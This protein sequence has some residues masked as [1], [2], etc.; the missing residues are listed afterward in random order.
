MA[1]R[2]PGG[3]TRVRH[4]GRGGFT[5]TELLLVTLVLGILASIAVPYFGQAR[6]RA[7]LARIQADLHQLMEGVENHIA[8]NN[9]LFPSSIEELEARSTYTRTGDVEYCLFTSV[10][11]TP[12]REPYVIALA[13]DHA[14]TTKVLILYPLWGSQMLDFDSGSR[15]C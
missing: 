4:P 9:G 10:P 2:T 8:L 6:E 14:T 13:G 11:R 15:G 3:L 12:W 7:Y 5:L 1:E